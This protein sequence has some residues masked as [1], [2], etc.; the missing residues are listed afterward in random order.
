MT[1]KTAVFIEKNEYCNVREVHELE[2]GARRPNMTGE[3]LQMCFDDVL[4]SRVG[5]IY[6]G[7]KVP[8]VTEGNVQMLSDDG[9]RLLGENIG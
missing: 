6:K 1:L 9:L 2:M 4:L 5:W 7:V 8:N 3:D